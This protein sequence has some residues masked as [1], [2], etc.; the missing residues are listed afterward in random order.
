MQSCNHEAI[1]EA[2]RVYEA[3]REDSCNC[4]CQCTVHGTGKHSIGAHRMTVAL[5]I[6]KG[7]REL[8]FSVPEFLSGVWPASPHSHVHVELVLLPRNIAFKC[9]FC[10]TE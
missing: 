5:I 1:I 10:C 8:F 4:T 3:D 6:E 7:T 9:E 2:L